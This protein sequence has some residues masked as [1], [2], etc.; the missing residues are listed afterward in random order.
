MKYR[1]IVYVTHARL[2]TEKAHGLATIKL[3]EAF[4]AQGFAVEL[5][6]PRTW[7]ARPG[8]AFSFYDVPRTFA[9]RHIPMLDLMPLGFERLTFLLGALTFS[10]MALRYAWR[11]RRSDVIF[12]SHDHIPLYFLTFFTPNVFY[13]IH[14]FPGRNFIYRRVLRRA[15][16]FAVQTRWKREALVER[17]GVPAERIVYWPNGTDARQFAL[18]LEKREARTRLGVPAEHNMVLYTGQLFF[19]KGVE[20]LVAALPWLSEAAVLY[21][22]GG[23]SQEAAA[24]KAR[25]PAGYAARVVFVPFQPHERIPL[26][27]RAAD[28]LVL[29]NT[30]RAA[31]S[32]YYT[33]PMKLF[34]YMAAAQPIVAS[35][36]PSILEILNEKNALFA[37]PDNPRS[38]ADQINYALEHGDEVVTLGAQAQRD[39]RKYTWQNRAIK[40]AEQ[41]GAI[42]RE[43]PAYR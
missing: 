34:E 8:D 38:F 33:S 31:V 22:V 18:A 5:V 41:F 23:S 13:D 35:R 42:S 15:L 12:F 11:A 3:C 26:W 17:F 36:I 37:E 10:L 40:I 43:H 29:P 7:R 24:L 21:I 25:I 2:P 14:H 27:L 32:L 20:T 39:V 4:A 19:W 28:V 1:T 30:G 16:G 9:V 6:V